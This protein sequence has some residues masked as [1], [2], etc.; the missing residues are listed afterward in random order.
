M[1]ESGR[2]GKMLNSKKLSINGKGRIDAMW[3][4]SKGKHS[5]HCDKATISQE[6]FLK[7]FFH[8]DLRPQTF[9]LDPPA[10]GESHHA[11][12]EGMRS[13]CSGNPGGETFGLSLGTSGDGSHDNARAHQSET[14]PK[15]KTRNDLVS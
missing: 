9:A 10:G 6:P 3:F 15:F 14:K 7:L 8:A 13:P 4:T 1:F 12:A 5:S 11:G 2:S